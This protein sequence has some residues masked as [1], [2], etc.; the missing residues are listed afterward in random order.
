MIQRIHYITFL[1]CLAAIFSAHALPLTFSWVLL[2]HQSHLDTLSEWFVLYWYLHTCMIDFLHLFTLKIM[3]V[4]AILTLVIFNWCIL[5][6][7][8]ALSTHTIYLPCLILPEH[9]DL[10]KLKAKLSWKACSY[11]DNTI[12]KLLLTLNPNLSTLISN[13]PTSPDQPLPLSPW[14][15]TQSCQN[16]LFYFF[17]SHIYVHRCTHNGHLPS[18]LIMTPFIKLSS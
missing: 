7:G 10:V 8:V 17:H 16:W 6:S 4:Q 18:P 13:L 11:Q 3:G 12:R 15:P 9:F 2:V 1:C 5:W 14:W